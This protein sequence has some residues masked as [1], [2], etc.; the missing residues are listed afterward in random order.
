MQV[1]SQPSNRTAADVGYVIAR[2]G[3]AARAARATPTST[4]LRRNDVV[5]EPVWVDNEVN[6]MALGEF[7]QGGSREPDRIYVKMGSGTKAG[8][9]SGG[10]LIHGV[11]GAAGEIG[12]V[13]VSDD[14]AFADVCGNVGCLNEFTGSQQLAAAG[15][16]AARSG[17]SASL[18]E[19]H[20]S[21]GD[22]D[23]A[24]VARACGG[25]SASG[26]GNSIAFWDMPWGA[27]AY[28]PAA[29]ALTEAYKP[30]NGCRRRPTRAFRGTTSSRRSPR[31][32]ARAR[33]ARADQRVR[34][35][36]GAD[37]TSPLREPPP[38]GVARAAR[39]PH[40]HLLDADGP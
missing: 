11:G 21:K 6:L 36:R 32:P 13:S 8:I 23:A 3:S 7:R 12:H 18:R 9:I 37:R 28:P 17:R 25:G 2:G 38:G 29:Q 33:D 19:I 10:R 5:V 35:G 15:R 4:R 39:C 34:P 22:L 30:A 20:D 26:G 1:N 24:D 40:R 14:P 31:R 16:E 27:A